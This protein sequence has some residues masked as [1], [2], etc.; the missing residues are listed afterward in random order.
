M[1]KILI[2]G[3][4]GFL[5]KSIAE[6]LEHQ[7]LIKRCNRAVLDL[8]NASAVFEFLKQES[9]DVVIHTATYDA[10]PKN[11]LK[12]S[13]LVLENNLNMFFNLARCKDLYGKM[14]YFGSG[15]EFSREHWVSYM[16]ESY[17]DQ[18]VPKDQYGFSKYVMA[19]YAKTTN[20]IFNL[21]LFGV[22][23]EYDD[24]R[25]RFISNICCHAVMDMPVKVHQNARVDFLYINDL[26]KIVTWFI[27]NSPKRQ[28]YNVCTAQESEYSLIAQ[29][30]IEAS[31]KPLSRIVDLPICT[32]KYS[33]N[34]TF[35][36]EEIGGMEFTPMET[37]LK[38][39]YGWYEEHKDIVDVKQFHY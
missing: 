35:L 23:G 6:K 4:D 34:N 24:W 29:R 31:G 2:T 14:L 18:Y 37:A 11:S 20:N 1:K 26:A 10:A 5:A 3:G 22:F 30:V 15:A 13:G 25:Y 39:L 28:I 21:R 8:N 16:P 12:D 36:L 19:K 17:F 33:G 38:L 7:Y 27:E 9:F 32:R